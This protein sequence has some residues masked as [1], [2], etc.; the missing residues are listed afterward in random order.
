[1]NR[2]KIQEL[3]DSPPEDD[4]STLIPEHIVDPASQRI[5]LVSIFVLI[6]CWKIYD[7]LLVKADL[8]AMTSSSLTSGPELTFTS[9][10]NFTFVIK[11]IVIDGLFLWS[12]PILNVPLLSFGPLLTLLMTV[13]VN[14]FTFLLASSSALP[15][16]SGIIVPVWN[17]FFKHK[18][19]NIVGDSVL[20]QKVIDIN[21]HFKGKYTIHYLP[22]ASVTLNPFHYDGLCLDIE[23]GSS[24]ER[25]VWVPIEFNTT[26]DIESMQ[27]QHISPSNSMTLLNYTS[28]DISKLLKRD[29]AHLHKL[30][31]HTYDERIFYLE[32]EIKKPGKYRIQSV[33]DSIGMNI[34]PYKSDFRVG[35]CPSAKF[36]YP[37][38][39]LAYTEVK[40]VLK[41]HLFQPEW[42]FP[43]VS[44]FGVF[45]L[46]IEIMTT[47]NG[48]MINK[49]NATL[50][51]ENAGPGLMWLNS[52]QMTRNTLEQELLRNPSLLRS[53]SSGKFE[54]QILSVIDKL[55]IRRD[56]NPASHDQDINFS[57]LTRESVSL[58]LVDR[59]PD[60]PLLS[61]QSKTLHLDTKLKIQLPL[62]VTV[63]YQE[64]KDSSAKKN[65]TY[66]FNDAQDFYQGIKIHKAGYYSL[67]AGEDRFCP[68]EVNEEVAIPIKTPQVPT[69]VIKGEPISDRCVG[70][71]G[72]EFDFKFTGKPPFEVLYEVFKNLSGVLKPILSE[73]GLRQ[74]TKRTQG[75][76]FRFDYRP[77]QEGSYVLIFKLLKDVYYHNNPIA[78]SEADN[79]FSTYFHQKS[80]YTF[81]KDSRQSHQEMNACNGDSIVA[82]I[83]FEGNFPFLFTYE[84]VEANSKNVLVSRKVNEYFQDTFT[85]SSP[86]FDNGGVFEIVL[87]D[88]IDNL[89]C[90]VAPLKS[91]SI[92]INARSDIPAAQFKKSE[93][94]EIIEGDSIDIPIIVKSSVGSTSSDKIK[95][96]LT[97][98]E[99]NEKEFLLSG[100]NN[101]RVSKEGTYRLVSFE[102]KG[103]EGIV[104]SDQSIQVKFYSKPSMT[105]HPDPADKDGLASDQLIPLKP[106][107]QDASR[108]LKLTLTGQPPFVVAYLIN[109]PHGKTKS[110]SMVIESNEISIPLTLKR[111]GV[112]EHIF[113]AVYDSR[114]TQDIS[115]RIN[116]K[117][118][119]PTI[120]YEV[121]GSPS[122]LVDKTH[123]QFCENQVSDSQFSAS[124]PITFEGRFP[125]DLAGSIQN[126]KGDIIEK[127]Q[128][129]QV[130]KPSVDLADLKLSKPLLS[131]LSVGEYIISF[132][133]ITDANKCHLKLLVSQNTVTIS[134]TRV[135]IIQKQNIKDY[136]CVGEHIAYNM[137]GIAP[138]TIFY[139]FNGQMRKAEQG[140]EFV[141][142]ASKPG[143][144]AIHALKDSSASLC[145]VNYT[146]E[147]EFEKL[148][149][150]VRDLPSVEIS[151][152]DSIIKN[153]HEG[154]KTEITFKFTGVPPFQVTYVRTLGDDDGPHKR[155]KPAKQQAKHARRVAE[156]KT[157][158]DIWDYEYTEI[159]GLEG[160]YEAIMIADAFCK[161][162]RNVNEIL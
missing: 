27:I 155:R 21:S 57:I 114:Y 25:S 95:Y 72:F 5:F 39:E 88:V 133:E 31:S 1:M 49:F 128:V 11:Y 28:R 115:R 159:V 14:A 99:G 153:L 103:C 50:Q 73:R 121:Q 32:V 129:L 17:T 55:G 141:R 113:T 36:V 106:I 145:L 56:Y 158:K 86:K 60:N 8:Y 143:V 125:F 33:T 140:H 89:G 162:S 93:S 135:P 52:E 35:N 126:V 161:A 7:I 43:L 4:H 92:R 119:F 61:G 44:A 41:S 154:D 74:H 15:F 156:K 84:I 53:G 146:N 81:F 37:E 20:P 138:F 101:L 24:F 111:K 87:K 19:L 144:L 40:C 150:Q 69:V 47:F 120:R 29:Y 98:R 54:F 136:Y 6:Q 151:H 105:F 26:S 76:L 48:K 77:R 63:Q 79:T 70:T 117:N 100:S 58:L 13:I 9:L 85:I 75:E 149:L 127:F 112:Y 2:P 132:Q 68:C 42:L 80:R 124:L 62:S 148:K 118:S 46:S 104:K 137:S 82:P 123:M 108:S 131:L 66:V 110:S 16:L 64:E 78:I 34:R 23:S 45:P 130:N 83:H 3:E 96:S 38:V 122:L 97:D 12:L 91:E 152:G 94:F 107:C 109:Y 102:N 139:E 10:N 51:G 59:S 142:L 147:S 30:L 160:T 65:L 18:E 67:L 116:L 134:I 22:A 71:V 157:I 90:P